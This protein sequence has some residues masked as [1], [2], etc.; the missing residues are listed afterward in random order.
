MTKNNPL[1]QLAMR[2]T[3]AIC[4]ATFDTFIQHTV[5]LRTR[6]RDNT[7]NHHE[8]STSIRFFQ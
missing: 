4:M 3:D 6:Q 1:R 2:V 7:S 8:D 5:R